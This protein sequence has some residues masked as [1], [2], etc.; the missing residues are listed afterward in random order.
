MTFADFAER[1][2]TVKNMNDYISR[3][4]AI[5]RFSP[6]L[7]VKGYSEGEINMLK[8]V[9]YELSCMPSADVR[10]NVKSTWHHYEGMYSCNH[11]DDAFYDSS[12]FCPNCGADMRGKEHE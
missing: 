6:W 12:P 3:Q 4:D 5:N 8:A 2:W 11:C 7:S 10:E 9:L 1:E